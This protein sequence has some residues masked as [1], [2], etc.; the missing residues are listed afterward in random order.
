MPSSN[1]KRNTDTTHDS[2]TPIA[3]RTR[4]LADVIA[5]LADDI[6][7]RF[8]DGSPVEERVRYVRGVSSRL[9]F[10]AAPFISYM[11]RRYHPDTADIWKRRLVLIQ[12]EAQACAAYEDIPEYRSKCERPSSGPSEGAKRLATLYVSAT[13]AASFLQD[14]AADF[15]TAERRE[16]TE[17]VRAEVP[18]VDQEPNEAGYVRSPVDQTAYLP[19]TKI[20][21]E[22]T[23]QE[24]SLTQKMVVGIIEDFPRNGVR[25]SKPASNRRTVHLADWTRYISA[26]AKVDSEGFPSMS[27]AEIASRKA[28]ARASR[29]PKQR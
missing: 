3:S 17:P 23:P 27:Q 4:H 8:S 22:H 28:A 11:E 13:V 9:G 1:T 15:E 24:M 14:L 5:G 29:R 18:R 12:N 26:K 2:D 6:Q 21:Q 25:W 16:R 7:S 10:A 20:V 19:L